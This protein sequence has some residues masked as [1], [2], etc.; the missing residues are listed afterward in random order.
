MPKS[1]VTYSE[2]DLAEIPHNRARLLAYYCAA[3]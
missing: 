2:R 3:P 1:G